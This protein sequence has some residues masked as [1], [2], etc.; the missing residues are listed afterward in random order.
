MIRNDI[1]S[2]APDQ[3]VMRVCGWVQYDRDIELVAQEGRP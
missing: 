3:A 2:Q 1:L